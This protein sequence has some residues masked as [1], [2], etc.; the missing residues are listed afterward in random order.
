[1][2][3]SFPSDE[4]DDEDETRFFFGAIFVG[5]CVREDAKTNDDLELEEDEDEET[6]SNGATDG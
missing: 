2:G 1:M 3:V 4:D 6:G 5:V